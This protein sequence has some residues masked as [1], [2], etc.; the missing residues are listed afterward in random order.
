[1]IVDING[2]EKLP[3]KDFDDT[4][5]GIERLVGLTLEAR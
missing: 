5:L 3:Q 2:K 1:M 4:Y